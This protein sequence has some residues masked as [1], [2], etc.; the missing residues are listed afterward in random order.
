MSDQPKI[1]VASAHRYFSTKCFNGAWDLMD[2]N[3][4]T[5]EEDL[6][7]LHRAISGLWHWTQREDCTDTNRSISLWQVSRIY[8]LL[9]QADNARKYAELSRAASQSEGV[10]PFYLGYAYEALARAEALAGRADLVKE[11]LEMGKSLAGQVADVEEKN[12]L[13]RDLESIKPSIPGAR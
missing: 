1:D 7:M 9:G 5:E 3:D 2:R 10:E 6:E 11:L 8:S 12:A 4:R 13:I